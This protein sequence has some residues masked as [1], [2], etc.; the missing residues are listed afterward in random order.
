MLAHKQ[1]IPALFKTLFTV[2]NSDQRGS[3]LRFSMLSRIRDLL[4]IKD[5]YVLLNLDS[6]NLKTF[7]CLLDTRF[8][9]QDPSF[10]N[11]IEAHQ[12]L[13]RNKSIGALSRRARDQPW[14]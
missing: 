6:N 9:W 4:P 2:Q 10:Y 12:T 8:S 13:A 11:Q 7:A 3:L 5:C 1:V 14:L